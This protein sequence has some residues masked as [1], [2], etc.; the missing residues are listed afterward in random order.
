[1]RELPPP[2]LFDRSSGHSRCQNDQ[3]EGGL[4]QVWVLSRRGHLPLF[5]RSESD[6]PISR[7]KMEG[8]TKR[9]WSHYPS[10]SICLNYCVDF[11]RPRISPRASR[12]PARGGRQLPAALPRAPP[13]S[14]QDQQEVCRRGTESL[15]SIFILKIH[16]V[17]AFAS[18]PQRGRRTQLMTHSEQ[19]SVC[20][21]ECFWTPFN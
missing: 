18:R 11:F 1:M 5:G 14:R 15:W 10:A 19:S 20:L 16:C 9:G 17:R 6:P 2:S 21:F 12:R 4:I 8:G 3:L 13:A 7:G